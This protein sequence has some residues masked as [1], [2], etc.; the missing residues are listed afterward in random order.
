MIS[1]IPHQPK[2]VNISRNLSPIPE[3]L[4]LQI[5]R[6]YTVNPPINPGKLPCRQS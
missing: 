5:K 2:P 1:S 6:F 4:K 3:D